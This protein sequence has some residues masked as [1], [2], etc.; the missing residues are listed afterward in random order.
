V[1][2]GSSKARCVRVDR[3]WRGTGKK[4]ILSTRGVLESRNG[5]HPGGLTKKR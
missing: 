4:K 1:S 3:R 5:A 2:T